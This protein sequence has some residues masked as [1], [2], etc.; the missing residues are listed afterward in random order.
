MRCADL[1]RRR[2]A[3]TESAQSSGFPNDLRSRSA[4]DG[5]QT[6]A[7]LRQPLSPSDQTSCDNFQCVSVCLRAVTALSTSSRARLR[8]ARPSG[9]S[10]ARTRERENIE[11]SARA[12]ALNEASSRAGRRAS[13]RLRGGR[14][15][16]PCRAGALGARR[17]HRSAGP[18]PQAGSSRSNAQADAPRPRKQAE[19]SSSRRTFS[20]RAKITVYGAKRRVP[21]GMAQAPP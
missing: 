20:C 8:R 12:G 11:G 13:R 3:T 2:S 15:A 7:A 4:V 21:F 10:R 14:H 1:R 6:Q 17:R 16:A 5:L 19:P 9:P 18:H